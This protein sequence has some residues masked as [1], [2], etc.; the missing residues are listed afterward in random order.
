[1][2]ERG[3][4]GYDATFISGFIAFGLTYFITKS[5]IA[6]ITYA[7]FLWTLSIVIFICY[8]FEIVDDYYRE[9]KK[10]THPKGNKLTNLAFGILGVFALTLIPIAV[11]AVILFVISI[12]VH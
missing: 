7:A 10:I 4:K 6:A 12:L 8:Y 11:I 2:L 9:V 1:M 5:F 3:V